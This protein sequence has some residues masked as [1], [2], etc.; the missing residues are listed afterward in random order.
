MLEDVEC[1]SINN[2]HHHH[3][4]RRK[5]T[6]NIT[7]TISYEFFP[8]EKTIFNDTYENVNTRWMKLTLTQY[9]VF[10]IQACEQNRM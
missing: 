10:L 8:N 6:H 4:R 7:F 5:T 9:F 1:K 3:K 2:L